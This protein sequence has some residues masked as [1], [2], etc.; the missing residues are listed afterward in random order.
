M[1][2]MDDHT[3][4]GLKLMDDHKNRRM[5]KLGK[6]AGKHMTCKKEEK[7]ECRKLIKYL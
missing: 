5:E 4:R 3:K 6:M 7:T 1:P 2:L